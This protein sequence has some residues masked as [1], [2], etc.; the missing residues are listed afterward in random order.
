VNALGEFRQNPLIKSVRNFLSYLAYK[1]RDPGQPLN[2]YAEFMCRAAH[3]LKL[4]ITNNKLFLLQ[5][6]RHGFPYQPTV[7]AYDPVQNILAIGTKTGALRMYPL[8]ESLYVCVWL[9]LYDIAWLQPIRLLAE[10]VYVCIYTPPSFREKNVP[11]L[12]SMALRGT[13]WDG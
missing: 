4:I 1:Q 11:V 8:C 9:A 13:A 7:L 5:T 6:F 2:R 12:L 10:P 3:S